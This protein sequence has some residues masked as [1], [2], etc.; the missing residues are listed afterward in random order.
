MLVGLIELDPKIAAFPHR[1]DLDDDQQ[2]EHHCRSHG[3]DA[4]PH[5]RVEDGPPDCRHAGRRVEIA[6]GV[7]TIRSKIVHLAVDTNLF[8][9]LDRAEQRA[10]SIS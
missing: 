9:R 8:K 10:V 4:P 3:E 7:K 5:D 1:T 2:Y 6:G